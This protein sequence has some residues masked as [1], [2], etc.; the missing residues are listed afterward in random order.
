MSGSLSK[1]NY[2]KEKLRKIM[3]RVYKINIKQVSFRNTTNRKAGKINSC[4]PIKSELR[5]IIA[6][7]VM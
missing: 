1:A 6:Y 7:Y 2:Q 5:L 4:L 3:T